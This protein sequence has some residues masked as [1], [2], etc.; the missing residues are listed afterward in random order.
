MPQLLI[1]RGTSYYREYFFSNA[2][3]LS[4]G[5]IRGN[6]IYL[7]DASHRVSRCHAAIVRLSPGSERYFIRD[8]GSLRGVRVAGQAVFQ[9]VLRE[10]DVIEIAG[11][12]LIYSSREPAMQEFSPL[13]VVLKLP[14]DDAPNQATKFLTGHEIE[15]E[16]NFSEV[17][18]EV[19]D[20][21]IQA[22]KQRPAGRDLLAEMLPAITRATEARRGFAGIF[23]PQIESAFD[24]LCRTGM[25]PGDQIEITD[26]S[27]AEVLLRGQ[28]LL[29]GRTMLVPVFDRNAVV[30]FLGLERPVI[31]RLVNGPLSQELIGLRIASGDKLSAIVEGD[32]VAFVHLR[33]ETDS[34]LTV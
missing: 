23:R 29:E 33:A 19:I 15:R 17:Q 26:A 5:R 1:H 13:R 18:K 12:E 25:S 14:N 31:D 22:A 8:L 9:H 6:D 4:I 2:D 32:K 30:G 16:I 10:G 28:P 3:C 27:F 7:P 11:F 20:T 34:R 24:V 21:L